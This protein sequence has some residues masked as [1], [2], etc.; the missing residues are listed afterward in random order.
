MMIR[1]VTKIQANLEFAATSGKYALDERS[2]EGTKGFPAP[3]PP[4]VRPNGK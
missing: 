4:P 3:L 2:G 1:T